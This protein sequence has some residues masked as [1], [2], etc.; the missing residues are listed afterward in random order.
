MANLLPVARAVRTSINLSPAGATSASIKD[1]LVLGTANVID[2]VERLRTYSSVSA[3]ASDFGT[4]G[5]EYLAAQAWFSQNPQP[6]EILIGRWVNAASS[7]G[8]RC[9]SLTAAQ[10]ALS[11]FTA[12]TTGKFAVALNGAAAADIGPMNFSGAANLN[13]VAAIITT[14]L[15]TATCVWNATLSR[16]EM[17]SNTTGVTSAVSF[18]TAPAAGVDISNILAGRATSSGAYVFQGQIAET[19]LAAANLFDDMFGTKWYALVVPAAVDADHQAL[20]AAVEAFSNKHVYGV[21]SASAGILSAVSTTDI[22]YLLQQLAVNRTIVQYSSS[23]PYAVCSLLARI[24]TTDYS[25]P[26]STI[27]LKFKAEPGTVAENL[28]TTQANALEAKNCNVFVAYANNT[29]IVEQGVMASGQ[30]ADV[31]MGSDWLAG[32]AR[33]AIYNVLYSSTSKIPQTDAG[34][35]VLQAAVEGV[36]AQGVFNG[37]MA[38]GVWNAVS[39]GQL[40]TGDFLNK[41]Y[42]IYVLPMALQNPIDRAAR[43][44]PPMTVAAKFAGAI[45][46]AD[47]VI[48]VNQ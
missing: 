11:V 37:L 41:G 29:S 25:Q 6:S 30:Y 7:G 19:A 38:P 45:H 23:N 44:C 33:D 13:A 48:D 20:A 39:F 36:C 16:F 1:L 35:G 26:N 8:L 18:I 10:S 15:A 12:I 17:T 42:Y 28:T 22:A 31:I 2:P 40:K 21:T 3:V 27:T 43:K 34:A 5:A 47:V 9:A 4:T 46:S 32:A 24:L 14:A